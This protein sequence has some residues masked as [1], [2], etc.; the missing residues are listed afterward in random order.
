MMTVRKR[1][2]PLPTHRLAMRN[3]VDYSSSY[4]FTSDNSSFITSTTIGPSHSSFVSPSRK[5]SRSPTTSVSISLPLPRS[6]SPSRVALLPPLKRIWIFNFMTDLEDCSNESSESSIPREISL[7]DDVVVRGSDE[8]YAETDI[9]PKIQAKI[10][11]CIAYVDALRAEG[12]DAKVVVGNIGREEVK[13]SAKGPVEVRVKRVTHLM[14]SNDIPEPAQEE[15][16]IKGTY[17]TL[18]ALRI[19]ELDQDNTRPRG[20]LDVASQRVTRL[21]RRKLRVRREMKTLPN[22][23]SGATI[24]RE[25]VNELIAH[26]VAKALEARDAARNLKPLVE[27]GGEQKDKN[28]DDYEGGNR[29]GNGNKNGNGN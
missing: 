21:Q 13:T 6:L 1:V 18:G 25:A 2:G 23:R 16:A 10:D 27:G 12:I 4:L 17:E 22:T 3:S 15:R 5:R 14:V 9:D 11:E 26:R 7:R 29:G 24:T 20:T 19:S 8:S 28:G